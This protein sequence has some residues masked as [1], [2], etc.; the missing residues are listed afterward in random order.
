VVP[1]DTPSH[2]SF[3]PVAYAG[4]DLLS[5]PVWVFDIDRR[6]VHWANT[7]AL[8]IWDA[9]TLTELR[10][11]DMGRDMS[12]SVA[13][14]LAQ[15]Q[16]DF[17]ASGAAFNEQWTL[18]PG[19]R[20]VSLNVR[21]SGHRLDD[22][23]MAMLCEGNPTVDITPESLR[24]VEA[25]LHTAV[26][27]TLYDH[28]GAPL[29][30]NP[31][32]RE[33]ATRADERLD[34]RIGDETL[35]ADLKRAVERNGVATLTVLVRTPRGECWHELS[36]R[37]C[38]DAV[39]AREA[40]LI[41]ETD[42]SAVKRT[43]ERANF[44]A[45]HDALTGLPNRS[46]LTQQF[47]QTMAGLTRSGLQAALVFID[48]DHF[49]D[50]N[51]TLGHAAGDA[52]LVQIADRLRHATRSSDVVARLGGD[53]FLILMVSSDIRAAVEH[54]RTRLMTFIA[55]PLQLGANELRMTASIGVALYPD[56]GEDLDTLLPNADLALYA[57]KA[58]GRN[59]LALYEASMAR[60]V[61]ARLELETELRR[62]LD[63]RE[64]ELHYQPRVEVAT[65]RVVGAEALVRWRHPQRGL[66]FPDQFIAV[67][68]KTGLIHALGGFVLREAAKQQAAW[69]KAGH[70][71]IVS[72]NLSVRQLTHPDLLADINDVLLTTGAAP[73]GLELEITESML[74]GQD[75]HL[76]ELLGAIC[77][78]GIGIGLDDFGT[79]YSNLAYLQ[80][81]PIRTLKIDRTFIQAPAEKRHLASVIVSMCRAMNFC[82]V[83]E[84]VET[85]EQR[86]WIASQ[87]VNEFQGYLFSRPIPAE[88]FEAKLTSRWAQVST[89]GGDRAAL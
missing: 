51:D 72:V 19:G 30:R 74:L 87:G 66:I 11:R 37:R 7:A 10:A 33:A 42:I 89:R 25:L 71:L 28:A 24:S 80:Q 63:K 49:K 77:D 17:I 67:C 40:L 21:F 41:S 59:D 56:D 81:F 36:A 43:E 75:R 47:A 34:E 64:F 58:R 27:I 4:L 48:L 65:G 68:E 26:M 45:L 55:Q 29:Y 14:R 78:L 79:G 61:S 62:A 85:E 18:Y 69:A 88:E 15:Y 52:L 76:H 57:A 54:V 82:A 50:V 53:E 38:R 39:T 1:N 13:R 8:R 3:A 31:A 35:Y 44:M 83:A 86:A 32:A 73:H 22:G 23:R 60:A 16:A 84:G 5:R 2:D 70:S 20:A 6:R 12:A 46:H 9:A